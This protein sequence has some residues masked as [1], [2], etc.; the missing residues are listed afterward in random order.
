MLKLVSSN[1]AR[2]AANKTLKDALIGKLHYEGIKTISTAG[3]ALRDRMYSA[4]DGALWCMS[5]KEE[6]A[7]RAPTRAI[8]LVPSGSTE[9]VAIERGEWSKIK[10]ISAI[11]ALRRRGLTLLKAKRSIETATEEGRVVVGVPVVESVDV[12]ADELGA[13]GFIP[14]FLTPK[15][16]DVRELRERLGL[17]VEQF[18]L[19]YGLKMDA[20]Q[21][22]EDGRREP[23]MA[24]KSYLTAIDR[25]P[26]RVAKTLA[27]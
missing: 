3:G 7:R 19:Q 26:E 14:T 27:F 5:S 22:W 11:L 23:D 10:S 15:A 13:A 20:V 18:A 9:V 8:D 4:G 24:A 1:A 16:P 21:N 6:F 12:L 2:A 25:D 17:S